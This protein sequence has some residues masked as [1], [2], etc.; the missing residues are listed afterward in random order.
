MPH[1]SVVAVVEHAGGT[2]QLAE[3][4]GDARPERVGQPDRLVQREAN[5]LGLAVVDGDV[6]RVEVCS[7]ERVDNR[8]QAPVNARQDVPS[9]WQ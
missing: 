3:P 7:I 2:H 6:V 4:H 9:G 8:V 5:R 1:H